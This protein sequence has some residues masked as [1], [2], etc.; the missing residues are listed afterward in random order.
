MTATTQGFANG[1]SGSGQG[2]GSGSGSASSARAAEQQLADAEQQAA[3][4][5][6][7][8]VGQ[9]GLFS[10]SAAPRD[11]SEIAGTQWAALQR[12]A[13]QR[14]T[15]SGAGAGAGNDPIAGRYPHPPKRLRA[16]G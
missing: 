13:K 10:S 9:P 5:S 2:S 16:R 8:L 6:A 11:A 4:T 14:G 1:A 7:W 3:A 15:A 12:L